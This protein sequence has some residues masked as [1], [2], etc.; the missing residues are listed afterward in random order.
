MTVTEFHAWQPSEH[1]DRRWQ[2]V[3][4]RPF[5]TAPASDDHGTI[6]SRAAYLLT[7]HLD[8]HLPACRVVT[9]PGVVP[10]V[11]SM[12]NERMPD[13]GVTCSPATGSQTLANPVVLIEMLSPSNESQTRANVWAYTTIPSVA[14]ILILNS[15]AI[16]GALLRRD[17]NG[18]WPGEPLTFGNG[19]AV[20]LR[21]I[22][23]TAPLIAFYRG[24]S[25]ADR[26]GG[27][28]DA[29]ISTNGTTLDGSLSVILCARH[30]QRQGGVECQAEPGRST[31]VSPN[32]P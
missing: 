25:L 9:A 22:G 14:D 3:D 21:S 26:G 5:D 1:P 13:L 30:N 29:L 7:A 17:G 23:F 10:R 15:T 19:E 18:D 16:E 28:G 12:T 32:F 11:R 2:L 6:Q 8:A 24:T 27:E 31:A 20:E 4:G